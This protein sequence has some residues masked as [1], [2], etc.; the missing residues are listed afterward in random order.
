MR[1]LSVEYLESYKLK[2]LFSDKTTKV[3]DLEKKMANPKGIFLPLKDLDYFKQVTIDNCH[4]SICWPNGA[5]I[6]PDVL[7][8]M[9][10]EIK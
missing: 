2:I 4:L 10:T 7:Y 5:D 3:I 8:E 6:C 9:G 1:I